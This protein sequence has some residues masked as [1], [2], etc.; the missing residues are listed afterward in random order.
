LTT[1]NVIVASGQGVDFSAT[2]GTGTSELFNDYETGTWT[3]VLARSSGGPITATTSD[4]TAKYTKVGNLVTVSLFLIITGITSQGTGE[5]EIRGLP[6]APADNAVG[7]GSVGR[8]DAFTT[9]VVHTCWVWSDSR[10]IFSSNVN[11]ASA[12]AVD[13]KTGYINLTMTYFV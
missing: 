4:V 8:N 5:N 12:T 9:D 10:I 11:S 2:P 13:W 6:F 1:G 3:P 7:A